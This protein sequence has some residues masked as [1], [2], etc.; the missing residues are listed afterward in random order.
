MQE[1]QRDRQGAQ[2]ARPDWANGRGNG[3]N[4]NW[5]NRAAPAPQAPVAPRVDQK[6]FGQNGQQPNYRN[7]PRSNRNLG[8][9]NGFN[10]NNNR[11]SNDRRP[12]GNFGNNNYAGNRSGAYSRNN[13]VRNNDWARYDRRP[14]TS[15][16]IRIGGFFGP[17]YGSIASRYYGHNYIYYSARNWTS[18]NRPWRIGYV[19]PPAMY[20]EPL[21]Y[22]LYF[23]LPPP[24]IG[25]DYVMCD[26]DI[27]IVG[28]DSGV[29]YD[30]ILPY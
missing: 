30:A 4:G 25:Y 1:A 2:Q 23:D 19:L 15:V 28:E 11:Y 24:P 21:P 18:W 9:R 13:W 20:C 12:G 8:D 16:N 3:G 6:R 7:D 26:G 22:D 10:G 5:Q 17:S 14:R 29:V 27:L